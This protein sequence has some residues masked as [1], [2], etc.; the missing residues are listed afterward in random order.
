MMTVSPLTQSRRLQTG[1]SSGRRSPSST[2][3][4]TS[5][6]LEGHARWCVGEA[7]Q[8]APN[9]WL[10]LPD[11]HPLLLNASQKVAVPKVTADGRR[12]VFQPESCVESTCGDGVKCCV[13]KCSRRVP[14]MQGRRRHDGALQ[15]GV[16]TGHGAPRQQASQVERAGARPRPRSP[17]DSWCYLSVFDCSYRF[18][19]CCRLGLTSST[20]M[21]V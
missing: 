4:A 8:Q 5:S 3:R 19:S 11:C 20:S 7:S 15:G 21:A 1:R 14:L 16:H 12:V 6:G 2:T 13:S 17:V 10:L 9:S 18:C